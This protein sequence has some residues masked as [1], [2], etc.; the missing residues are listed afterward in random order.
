MQ[1]VAVHAACTEE[2]TGHW[3]R[4]ARGGRTPDV[5][6]T[7]VTPDVSK[8]SGWLNA[9]ACCRGTLEAHEEGDTGGGRR[10]GEGV[11]GRWRCTQR[12]HGGTDWALGTARVRGGAHVKHLAHVRDAGRVEGQRLVERR[13]V[14]P[15]DNAA[16]RDR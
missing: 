13:R 11:W 5:A 7:S 4:H 3:A 9:D 15:S 12:V 6:C 8:L 14:L 2:L 1:A 10:E 16:H